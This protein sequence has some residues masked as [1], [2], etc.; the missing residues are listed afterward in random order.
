MDEAPRRPRLVVLCVLS[1]GR[2]SAQGVGLPLP[3]EDS[4]LVNSMLGPCSTNYKPF[5]SVNQMIYVVS[6]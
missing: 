4:Q 2:A 3:A 1:I 5:Y 6:S